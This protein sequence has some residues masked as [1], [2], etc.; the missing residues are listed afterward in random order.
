M[1]IRKIK[2][3]TKQYNKTKIKI[4]NFTYPHN[5]RKSKPRYKCEIASILSKEFWTILIDYGKILYREESATL[6]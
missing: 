4:R 5:G 2:Q 3:N 1:K 6:I